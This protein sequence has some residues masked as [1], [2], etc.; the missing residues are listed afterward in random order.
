MERRRDRAVDP[1]PVSRHRLTPA[2]PRA[3]IRTQ[4]WA[5]VF[6]PA[7]VILIGLLLRIGMLG[8]DTRFHPDEALFATQA[9][10]ITHHGD[11]L[12]RETDLD[13]PPL[14]FYVTALSFAALGPTEFAARLPNVLASGASLAVLYALSRS[15][16][17]RRAVALVAALLWSLSP[18]DLAFAAT[19]FT[20]VQATLWTLVAALFAARGRWG[21][22]GIA[23]ALIAA[24][25]PTAL[26]FLPLIV[27][28][29][30]A[31]EASEDWRP[32][33]VLR[34]LGRF[35]AP[36]AA[37]LALLVLWDVA[38]APRSFWQL[39]L[40]RNNPGRFARSGEVWPRLERWL[41]WIDHATGSRALNLGL[42]TGA[43]AGAAGQA[44]RGN[45]RR[46]VVDWLIG[47]FAVAFLGW[48]WLIAFNTYDRYLHALIPFVL[49]LAARVLVMAW[50]RL[51][52]RTVARAALIAVVGMALLPGVAGALRGDAPVGG[53]QGQHTGIDALVDAINAELRG[54]IVYDHWLGWELAYYLGAEPAALVLY[55][56]L[57]EALAS[58]MATQAHP[59]YFVAPSPGHAAPWI[60]ALDRAGVMSA[61]VYHD[62]AHGFVV[63]RLEH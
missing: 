48:H 49:L 32:G 22:A 28:L 56:P 3:S 43:A 47:G 14:T 16:Y 39:G 60:A 6:A 27:A 51:G 31:R 19:A 37:G 41:R 9:R 45:D 35:A 53:D 24:S 46:T 44:L 12:L 21:W 4:L 29:G 38:R 17:R 36:L 7:L 34:R 11:H 62:T 10:L 5:S 54:E 25:K 1:V 18:F 42:A 55:T 52:A 58:D 50:D 26:L 13:K 15:L 30:L 8:I 61:I 33:D 63:Y 40:E 57:P 2:T 59:R 20:D 23:A